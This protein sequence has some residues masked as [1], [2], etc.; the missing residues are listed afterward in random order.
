MT[1][2]EGVT[3]AGGT[4]T[5]VA[6]LL[7]I[8]HCILS[9]RAIRGRIQETS[10]T[11]TGRAVG[12]SEKEDPQE[13]VYYRTLDDAIQHGRVVGIVRWDA[14]STAT[15]GGFADRASSDPATEDVPARK[16]HSTPGPDPKHDQLG[17]F[18]GLPIMGVPREVPPAVSPP[19]SWEASF[20]RLLFGWP[21]LGSNM[22]FPL[23]WGQTL[24]LADRERLAVLLKRYTAAVMAA[25]IAAAFMVLVLRHGGPPN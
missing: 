24:D 20:L 14:S 7:T 11:R 16:I 21:F 17:C 1:A 2:V 6:S 23:R 8:A 12:P 3:L 13:P 19:P 10:A 25:G 18:F 4:T 15:G 5:I 9:I 22:L